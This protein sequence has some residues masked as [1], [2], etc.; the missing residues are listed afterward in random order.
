MEHL[1]GGFVEMS[2]E[3]KYDLL[4]E[5]EGTI[6]AGPEQLERLD[7]LTERLLTGEFHVE[8]DLRIVC[9]CIDGRS[10][11][12]IKPNSAGGTETLMVMDDLINKQFRSNDGTTAGAYRNVLNYLKKQKHP[13]GGHDDEKCSDE[14]SGCGANDKLEDIYAIIARKSDYIRSLATEYGVNVDDETHNRI[15]ENAA[16]RDT[17]SKGP[18]LRKDLN[19]A[20]NGN[21]DHL[22]G[23]HK[24][25]V[26]VLNTRFGTTLDR[27]AL[28]LEFGNDYQAFNFDVWALDESANVMS[29]TPD[30]RES[31]MKMAAGVYYNLA[32]GIKLCGPDMRVV[33]LS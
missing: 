19:D 3:E 8:T 5:A 4:S 15:I 18:E 1:H 10:G 6:Q 22:K 26:L 33:V 21:F 16:S 24:E 13:I 2:I 23:S 14:A 29:T 9:G 7:E 27:E 31:Q 25:T 17:F 20:T 28:A 32:T 11:C 12:S 30:S